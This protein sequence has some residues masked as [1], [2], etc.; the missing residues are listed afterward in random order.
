M[1]GGGLLSTISC[2][3]QGERC[4]PVI[5]NQRGGTFLLDRDDSLLYVYRD[6]G[7]LG[8]SATMQRPL[9]FLDPWLN[10]VE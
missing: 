4:V 6:R 10:D 2:E 1:G 9:A 7:I 3:R 8:F 5:I